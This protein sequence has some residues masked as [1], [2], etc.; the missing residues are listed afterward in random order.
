MPESDLN[1]DLCNTWHS[2]LPV[3]LQGQLVAGH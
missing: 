3:D 1:P 2:A